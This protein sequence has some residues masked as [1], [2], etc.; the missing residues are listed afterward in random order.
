MTNAKRNEIKRLRKKI[1]ELKDALRP[2]AEV[3]LP[4]EKQ[5]KPYVWLYNG[6]VDQLGTPPHLRLF[7]FKNA[8]RVIR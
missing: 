3:E 7:D 1:A 6:E 5:G 2:F 4:E 8:R